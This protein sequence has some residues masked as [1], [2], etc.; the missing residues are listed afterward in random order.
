MAHTWAEAARQQA[1]TAVSLATWNPDALRTSL[2]QAIA[3]DRDVLAIQELRTDEATALGLHQQTKTQGFQ[4]IWGTLPKLSHSGKKGILNPNIPGPGFLV[5]EGIA[6]RKIHVDPLSKWEGLG[7][8]TAI[9]VF[10]QQRWITC[11]S[12]YAPV[13]DPTYLLLD[14]YNFTV[15]NTHNDVIIFGDLN[16]DTREGDMVTDL[17]NQG[18][19]PLTAWT[20]PDFITF[21]RKNAAS[22]I[23]T[24]I[25]SPSMAEHCQP[26]SAMEAY[27]KWASCSQYAVSHGLL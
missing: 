16:Q 25:L 27:K 22:C 12:A 23:D 8:C 26:I 2:A 21:R 17:H 18:W 1:T 9:Q 7:R 4:L 11:I 6:I 15:D 20:P 10:L 13:E 24:I 14:L 5:R 19:Y 3:F